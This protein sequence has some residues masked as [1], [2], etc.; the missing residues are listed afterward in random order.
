MQP[1]RAVEGRWGW[2]DKPFGEAPQMYRMAFLAAG[3]PWNCLVEFCT[4]RTETR[5]AMRLHFLHRNF[6]NTVVILEE[7][8][9]PHTQLPSCEVLVP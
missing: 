8:N 6:Q 4:G 3:G 2:A 1:G 5:T 7:G 9:L